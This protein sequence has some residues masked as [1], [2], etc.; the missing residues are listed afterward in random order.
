MVTCQ[1]NPQIVLTK[2]TPHVFAALPAQS[3][4]QSVPLSK[5]AVDRIPKTARVNNHSTMPKD[6]IAI[7]R[8]R[9]HGNNGNSH[10]A[11]DEFLFWIAGIAAK[12]HIRSTA[13]AFNI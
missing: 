2:Q 5:T 10:I 12:A 13:K 11:P 7:H 1:E 6:G 4:Q 3:G 9:I 8:A